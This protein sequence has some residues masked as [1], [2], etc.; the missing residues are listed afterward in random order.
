MDFKERPE[1]P[2]RAAPGEKFVSMLLLI[3]AI[4]LLVM[5]I[6]MAGLFD[7]VHFLRDR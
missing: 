4:S 3:L 7:L 5:P 2:G 6:S 1:P